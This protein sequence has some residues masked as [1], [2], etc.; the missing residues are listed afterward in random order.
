MSRQTINVL[1]ILMIVLVMV[2]VTFGLK[3]LLGPGAMGLSVL[4]GGV[5]GWFAA[6]VAEWLYRKNNP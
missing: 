1:A 4:I 5:L 6:D 3:A 2:P